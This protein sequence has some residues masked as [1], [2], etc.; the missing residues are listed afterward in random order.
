MQIEMGREARQAALGATRQMIADTQFEALVAL[1]IDTGAV[2]R[3]VMSVTLQR[4]ADGMI[5]KAR[6]EMETDVMVFPA[7]LFDRA[8]SLGEAAASLRRCAEARV[9]SARQ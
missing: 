2:P 9:S 8:R 3:N 5:A 4:L 7:E 1:L 6:G